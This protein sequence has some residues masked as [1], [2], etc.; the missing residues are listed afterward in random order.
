MP[1][2]C[3]AGTENHSCDKTDHGYRE[4]QAT[5]HGAGDRQEDEQDTLRR[6]QTGI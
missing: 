5:Q 6:N 2:T 4:R 1:Q 3:A